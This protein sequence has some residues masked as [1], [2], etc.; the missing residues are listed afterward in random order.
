MLDPES[1]L[2]SSQEP[3]TVFQ[4]ELDAFSLHFHT[5]VI[6]PQTVHILSSRFFPS[7]FWTKVVYEFLTPNICAACPTQLIILKLISSLMFC[8]E[9]K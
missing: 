5:T 7:S 3:A 8:K 9:C 4:S 2:P 1:S 6:M